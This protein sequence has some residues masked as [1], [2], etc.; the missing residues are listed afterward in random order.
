MEDI[1]EDRRRFYSIVEKLNRT[2]V[3]E[4]A[5]GDSPQM[6]VYNKALKQLQDKLGE[7][8]VPVEF[9]VT[10]KEVEEIKK[11]KFVEDGEKIVENLDTT[12]EALEELK[13]EEL[14]TLT[15]DQLIKLVKMLV[16][17]QR[18]F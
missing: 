9:K 13:S 6:K 11:T 10:L 5:G 1:V 2:Q 12:T 15:T 16:T 17:G 18:L 14:E 3:V 4:E 7:I 8:D